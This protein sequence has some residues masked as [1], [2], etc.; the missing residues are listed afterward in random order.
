MSFDTT[1]PTATRTDT[2][3]F[4]IPQNGFEK[5]ERTVPIDEPPPLTANAEFTYIGKPTIRYDGPAKVM[6]KG[7]YTADVN[8][9]GILYGRMVLRC[10]FAVSAKVSQ[11]CVGSTTRKN[12]G[13]WRW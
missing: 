10:F 13:S 4:G 5:K 8:L 6:G 12:S 2:F 3:V 1:K 9:P 7:K 11:S